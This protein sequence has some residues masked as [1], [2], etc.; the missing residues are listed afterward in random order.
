MAWDPL[1]TSAELGVA[2]YSGDPPFDAFGAALRDVAARC[3]ESLGRLPTVAELVAALD[4]ALAGA[5]AGSIYDP[6]S[7]AAGLAG[8]RRAIAAASPAPRRQRVKVG[9]VLAIPYAGDGAT[10]VYGWVIFVPRKGTPSPGLGVCVVVLDRDV[11]DGDELAEVVRA[12]PLL[13]PLHPNDREIREGAW[14]IVGNVVGDFAA[15]LPC[16]AAQVRRDSSWAHV[17]QDYGGAEVED[18]PANR[19]RVREKSVGGAGSIPLAVRA[20]RGDGR[21]LAGFDPWLPH[22]G[23]RP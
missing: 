1:G 5:P 3:G 23:R 19:A 6:Q 7:V 10:E 11:R 20:L 22:G 2:E 4:G 12:R 18:T 16:F 15:M 13:G 9:D 8:W 21:W 14:R 17:L